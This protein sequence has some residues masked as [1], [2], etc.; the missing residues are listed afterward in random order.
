MTAAKGSLP[1]RAGVRTALLSVA[2]GQATCPLTHA[3]AGFTLAP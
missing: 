3:G 2:H 1:A